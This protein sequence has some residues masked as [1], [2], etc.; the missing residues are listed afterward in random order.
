M[1]VKGQGP[2]HSFRKSRLAHWSHQPSSP[3]KITHLH[4]DGLILDFYAINFFDLYLLPNKEDDEKINL[5]SRSREHTSTQIEQ[6]F[7]DLV[8]FLTKSSF[9]VLEIWS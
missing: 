5:K 3:F 9:P 6:L 8:G 4:F 7:L 2:N 1:K